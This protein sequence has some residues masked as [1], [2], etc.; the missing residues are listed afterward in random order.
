MTCLFC[1]DV[2]TCAGLSYSSSCV[3][4]LLS[5]CTSNIVTGAALCKSFIFRNWYQESVSTFK[6]LKVAATNVMNF[7]HNFC[8]AFWN[9]IWLVRM[10]HCAVM[11][12]N[13]LIPHDGSIPVSVSGFSELLLSG[14]VRLLGVAEAF[15]ISFSVVLTGL[16]D[17]SQ[18]NPFVVDLA[19]LMSGTGAKKRLSRVP[20]SG[21]VSSGSSHKVKKPP[22]GAKLSNNGVAFKDSGSD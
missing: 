21:S 8:I 14:V 5:T 17:W 3:S 22:G 2:K 16:S 12:K 19:A 15:G 4:Q 11:E 13:E 7:M 6:D 20:T 18:T 9:D 10:K 1:D